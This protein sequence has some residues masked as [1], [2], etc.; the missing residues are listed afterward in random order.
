MIVCCSFKSIF[1]G[2]CSFTRRDRTRSSEIAPL[3]SRVCPVQRI[4]T[5]TSHVSYGFQDV[6]NKGHVYNARK[7]QDNDDLGLAVEKHLSP[8]T[9]IGP[10]KLPGL[11]RNGPRAYKPRQFTVFLD[12]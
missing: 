3:P 4:L 5:S 12:K 11:S 7:H 2:P 1:G 10:G 6:G 8:K 9:L